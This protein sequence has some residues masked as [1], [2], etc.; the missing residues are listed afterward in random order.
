MKTSNKLLLGA[1]I[2]LVLFIIAANV[3]LKSKAGDLNAYQTNDAVQVVDTI[4]A[5]SVQVL[6]NDSVK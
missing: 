4:T 2:I 1:F 3:I 5:D 6:T